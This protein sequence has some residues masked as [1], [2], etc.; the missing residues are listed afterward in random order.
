MT[1]RI[2]FG[3]E[4]VATLLCEID[5]R[6]RH[7]E[8]LM[9]R[10]LERTTKM[11]IDLSRIEAEVNEN[12]DVTDSAVVTL[13]AIAQMVRDLKADPTAIAALADRLD[14][15]TKALAEAIANVGDVTNPAV[16]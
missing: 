4:G 7:I 14:A 10:I 9:I 2:L 5:S 13:G 3:A 15:K 11:G 8:D 6:L 1:T 16:A 12:A